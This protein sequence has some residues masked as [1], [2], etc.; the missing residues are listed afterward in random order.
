M[1]DVKN[2]WEN[3]SWGRKLIVQKRRASLDD[4]DR[5]KLMAIYVRSPNI[6]ITWTEGDHYINL[7]QCRLS[8]EED[9]K[10]QNFQQFQ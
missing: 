10:I 8:T 5:F 7:Y 9:T 6:S 1:A 4:F 3:S 2:K